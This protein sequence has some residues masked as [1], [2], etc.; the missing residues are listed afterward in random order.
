MAQ[1]EAMQWGRTLHRV[2]WYTF[3]ADRRHGPV[4]LSK[5]DLSDGFYQLHLTPTGALKLAVL[6]FD[7][8]GHRLLAVPM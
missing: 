3:T 5:T 6:P 4:L 1:Q 7:H 8:H 2:L